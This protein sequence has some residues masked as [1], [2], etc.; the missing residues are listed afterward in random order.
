MEAIAHMDKQL[1]A[2][3]FNE[4]MRRYTEEPQRFAAEFQEAGLYL[5]EVAAGKTPSYGDNCAAY[6]QQLGQELGA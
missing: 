4:W 5:A 1:M 2:L 6:M 3:C